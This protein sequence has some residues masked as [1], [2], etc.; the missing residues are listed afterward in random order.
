MGTAEYRYDFASDN[1][2]GICPE[3]L[4]AVIQFSS[5][6]SPSY[7]DDTLTGRARG[8]VR[9]FFQAD[10]RVFFVF[11]GTAANSLA[12]AS[13]CDSHHG[14]LCHEWS[15]IVTDECGAP[16]FFTGG[17]QLL[18]AWSEDAKMRPESVEGIAASL[19]KI[20]GS[21]PRAL[22]LTQA[23]EIG[24]VY[25]LNELSALKSTA[26]SL[27]LKV[28]VDGAR[29]A[30]AAAAMN[31]HPGDIAREAG[32]DVLCLGGTKNG[33]YGTEAVVFLDSEAAKDF[34]YRCKQGG[35]LSSKMR[36]QAAQWVAMLET[37][38]FMENARRANDTARYLEGKL[39]AVP[40]VTLAWPRES[41][42]VFIRCRP[43]IAAGV[44]GRG[45]VFYPFFGDSW[46]LMCSWNTT[47]E[48]V[49]ALAK[50]FADEGENGAGNDTGPDRYPE[51]H[52]AG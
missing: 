6:C 42:G 14:I 13:L 21:K 17:G 50:D 49:D 24:T 48:A 9:D 43:E 38:A 5:G 27:G 46:R 28:H 44:R 10:C 19:R 33:M 7:G 22:S 16:G 18:T 12:L 29:L 15:H 47:A 36:F 20:H 4:D 52:E 40:G 32:A 3:A 34:E 37:G 51:G 1:T 8:L 25:G 26:A 35:Q 2:S 30:N 45:W 31:C 41:N 23:T 11:T 39:A